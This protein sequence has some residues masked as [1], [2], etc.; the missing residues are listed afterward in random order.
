MNHA[1]AVP[2]LI[3]RAGLSNWV[4]LFRSSELVLVDVGLTPT[5]V[6]GLE[7]G[8]RGKVTT[9]GP[10]NDL[11]GVA[12]EDWVMKLASSAKSVERIPYA[13]IR[14]LR[15]HRVL[16]AHELHLS[17]EVEREF[18]IMDRR[19]TDRIGRLASHF[20]PTAFRETKGGLYAWIEQRAEFLVR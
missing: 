8:V 17:T 14:E 19:A 1:Y 12:D 13:S 11:P 16:S 3:S 4:F 20:V 18:G 2:G 7:A 5:L 6:A 15:V 9:T 10:A